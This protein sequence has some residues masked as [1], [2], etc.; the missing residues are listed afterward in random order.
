MKHYT[1]V[2]LS[3]IAA[4]LD[5]DLDTNGIE[6]VELQKLVDAIVKLRTERDVLKAARQAATDERRKAKE[7]AG[8]MPPEPAKPNA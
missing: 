5:I 3:V 7:L 4:E 2:A 1:F 8:P 6:Q